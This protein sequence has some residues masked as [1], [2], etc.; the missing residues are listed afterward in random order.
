MSLNYDP[1]VAVAAL[2]E[3]DP[4]MAALI[5]RVPFTLETRTQ[6]PP[7]AALLRSI[8]YQQLSGKA[9]ATIHGRVMDLLDVE[10]PTTHPDPEALLALGEEPLRSAGVSRAKTAAL[11]D[12]AAKTLDG[13]VPDYDTLRTL[14]D[15]AVIERLTAVRGIG[16]WTAQM[17]LMFYLGRPDVLPATDLG[18]QKGFMRLYGL[19]DLPRPADLLAHGERWRPYR[20]V[21]SWYLW[22]V[23]ELDDVP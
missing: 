4:R 7:F 9:A 3:A 1:D 23:L 10:P 11:R 20:S 17:V 16:P 18:V 14:P 6:G 5:R 21:A 15:D 13:T 19:D 22:R 12:L 2:A 8:I